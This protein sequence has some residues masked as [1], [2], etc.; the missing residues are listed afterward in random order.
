M[1]DRLG[2]RFSPITKSFVKV[3]MFL[4]PHRRTLFSFLHLDLSAR[5]DSLRLPYSPSE[6]IGS[7]AKIGELFGSVKAHIHPGRH[8]GAPAAIFNPALATLQHR[9]DHLD[10]VQVT[11]QD[12]GHA[13]QYLNLA[14]GFYEDETA[15]ENAI[16][17]CNSWPRWQLEHAAQLGGWHQ[18]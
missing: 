9:L 15:R 8:G 5:L 10:Q 12:V 13:A 1:S 2:D 6:I 18:T 16:K 4:I 14:V 17:E 11:R 7:V 3:C